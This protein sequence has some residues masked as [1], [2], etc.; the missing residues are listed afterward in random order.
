MHLLYEF[1]VESV[2]ENIDAYT[3]K[4]ENGKYTKNVYSIIDNNSNSKQALVECLKR[5]IF[6]F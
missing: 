2:E 6:L 1:N 3:H 5:R 4:S